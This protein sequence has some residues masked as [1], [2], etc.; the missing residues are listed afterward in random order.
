[1]DSLLQ[2]HATEMACLESS[3]K[4]LTVKPRFGKKPSAEAV[5]AA[6]A[7]AAAK[8]SELKDKQ[9][10]ELQAFA[11]KGSEEAPAAAAA[12]AAAPAAPAAAAEASEAEEEEE[13]EEAEEPGA[14]AG[15]G[16]SQPK[17]SRSQ[18]RKEKKA[19]LAAAAVQ[20]EAASAAPA[21]NLREEEMRSLR[22]QLQPL[23]LDI[24]PI[25][26]DGH[27]LFRAV[28]AQLALLS[29]SEG[30]SSRPAATHEYP[31]LRKRASEFIRVYWED[32]YPFLSYLPS[33]GFPEGLEGA[34]FSSAARSAVGHYCE[35]MASSSAWGGHP[36]LRALAN[37]LGCPIVV[38]RA[39][40]APLQFE[41]RGE[42]LQLS[43]RAAGSAAASRHALRLSFHA[44]YT[45]L[46]EHYNSVVPAA[47]K[48]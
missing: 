7:Q 28:A 19:S 4:M 41:P 30:S 14:G 46:G 45:T 16:S 1:M 36:E 40:A 10:A 32:F 38:Y 33:D 34:A 9:A 20:S 24:S 37:V 6:E 17:A 3:L 43:G 47:A 23:S 29:S 5:A 27:C 44:Q 18:R 31:A 8:R 35:R 22:A 48:R 25:A 13:E 12:A 15:S 42:E 39:G 26:G 2:Q 11:E 21:V